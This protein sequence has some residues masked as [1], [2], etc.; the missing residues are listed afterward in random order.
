MVTY[1]KNLPLVM[2]TLSRCTRCVSEAFPLESCY[3]LFPVL[4]GE[5]ESQE[6]EGRKSKVRP[7]EGAESTAIIENLL[8]IGLLLLYYAPSLSV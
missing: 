8:K 6:G 7:L 1:P 3:F 5:G 2:L 4:F